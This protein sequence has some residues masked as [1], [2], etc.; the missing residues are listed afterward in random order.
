[1]A[2]E[3]WPFLVVHR[4]RPDG[5]RLGY[6]HWAPDNGRLAGI[7]CHGIS[8]GIFCHHDAERIRVEARSGA[9]ARWDAGDRQRVDWRQTDDLRL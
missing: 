5:F 2:W 6:N 9:R 4:S 8:Y 3:R 1:V 7:V